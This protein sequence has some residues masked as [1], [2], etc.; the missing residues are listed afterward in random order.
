MQGTPDIINEGHIIDVKTTTSTVV[1]RI[2]KTKVIIERGEPNV[3][4][5]YEFGKRVKH[6]DKTSNLIQRLKNRNNVKMDFRKFLANYVF[7]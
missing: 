5:S 2:F 1:T 4:W 7:S 6:Y 3:C